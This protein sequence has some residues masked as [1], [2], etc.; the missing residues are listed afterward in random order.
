[1]ILADNERKKLRANERS[2]L[3]ANNLD[4]LS[5]AFIAVGVLENTFDFTPGA[6]RF[7]SVLNIAAWIFAAL[8]L[9]F[10]ARITLGKLEP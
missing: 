9:H 6:G 3:L 8:V 1:M 10:M 7:L 2:K 4:R 5:T